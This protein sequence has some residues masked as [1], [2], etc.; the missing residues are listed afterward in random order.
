M[1][2]GRNDAPPT[3]DLRRRHDDVLNGGSSNVC[4]GK[5]DT[6]RRDS[7]TFRRPRDDPEAGIARISSPQGQRTTT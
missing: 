4:W 5:R 6:L 7:A 1:I 2:G 3:P